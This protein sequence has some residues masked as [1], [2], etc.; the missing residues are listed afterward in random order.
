MPW[1]GLAPSP[2]RWSDYTV[3]VGVALAVMVATVATRRWFGYSFSTW[4]F[5]LRGVDLK[6]AQDVG[7]MYDQ[8]VRRVLDRNPLRVQ[9]DT[10]L[11]DL[12]SMLV[13]GRHNFAL[14]QREDGEFVGI[15]DAAEANAKLLEGGHD[16]VIAESLAH[17]QD[18]ILTPNDRLS[19]ALPVVE[20]SEF[21]AVAVVMSQ[22]DHRLVGCVHEADLLRFYVEEADRMRREEIG[23]GGLFDDLTSRR[24]VA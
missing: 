10:P 16:G 11:V 17:K 18:K 24:D 20:A 21:D 14:V 22:T 15:V 1:S 9:A 2:P 23:E 4:R 19:T 3:T 6:G 5:H 8:T 7:R 12:C 13:L